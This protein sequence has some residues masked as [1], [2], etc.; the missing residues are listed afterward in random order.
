MFRGWIIPSA[1]NLLQLLS[2]HRNNVRFPKERESK[3]LRR[4]HC[5]AWP[6]TTSA[7]KASCFWLD[8]NHMRYPSSIY[9]NNIIFPTHTHTHIH[10]RIFLLKAP[11]MITLPKYWSQCNLLLR[12]ASHYIPGPDIISAKKRQSPKEIRPLRDNNKHYYYCWELVCHSVKDFSPK[13]KALVP[14]QR[15]K[16]CE[17]GNS[18]CV[19]SLWWEKRKKKSTEVITGLLM[20]GPDEVIFKIIFKIKKNG[21]DLSL[22]LGFH[23]C[24]TQLLA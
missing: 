16:S 22:E 10:K 13:P 23:F 21:Q 9:D 19:S 6:P 24:L 1:H 20:N 5:Q 15:P 12:A 7:T 18:I 4:R 17:D 3:H 11:S 14:S 2:A 8:G